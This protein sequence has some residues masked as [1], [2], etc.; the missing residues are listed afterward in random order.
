MSA[1][2]DQ[3]RAAVLADV[4]ARRARVPLDTVASRAL[5]QPSA[6]DGIRA[7]R[8]DAVMVIAEVFGPGGS[9]GALAEEYERAG[10]AVV[11][12]PG[13][14]AR[15]LGPRPPGDAAAGSPRDFAEVRACVEIPV[16][17]RDLVV[18]GYQ[19]WEARA[20][21]AD[22]VLLTAAVLEQEAMVS[23]V[24][25]AGSI[26]LGTVVQVCDPAE[27][28][29][30]VRAGA[31]IIAVNAYDE[32]ACEVDRDLSARLLSLIP[33]HIVRVAEC[34]PAGR[35]DLVASAEAGA[36]AVLVGRSLLTGNDPG[37]TAAQ[38]VS[39]GAHPALWHRRRK[40]SSTSQAV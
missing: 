39:A 37:R 21:G 13:T 24:E 17:S 2:W 5:A 12:V 11:S 25:R 3:I 8:G 19:L 40:P 28:I 10:A 33:G 31:G 36:D 18:S 26:G 15:T 23:L 32:A 4:A 30:A 16:L 9:A 27:T 20:Q 1:A 14:S 6:K 22:L 35:A 34:G 38:L 7:L 29:R